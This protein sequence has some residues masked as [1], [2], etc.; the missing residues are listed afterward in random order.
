MIKQKKL[1]NQNKSNMIINYYVECYMPKKNASL[2]QVME[3]Q[4][5]PLTEAQRDEFLKS[6]QN[7]EELFYGTLDT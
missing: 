1:M 7:F 6:L 3:K 4:R 5:Q 2:N